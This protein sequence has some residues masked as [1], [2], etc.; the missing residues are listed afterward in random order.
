MTAL[1]DQT[2]PGNTPPAL[3]VYSADQEAPQCEVVATGDSDTEIVLQ[4]D[5]IEGDCPIVV[6]IDANDPRIKVRHK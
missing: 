3:G 4:I 2:Y 6:V 1:T 5:S